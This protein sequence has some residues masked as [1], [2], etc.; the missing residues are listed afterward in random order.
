MRTMKRAI[1]V[2]GSFVHGRRVWPLL[3][4]VSV[5][6]ACAAAVYTQVATPE[7]ETIFGWNQPMKV[8]MYDDTPGAIIF[9]TK[10][11]PS[12]PALP[13]HNGATPT[14]TTKVF[15]FGSPPLVAVN[16]RAYFK[17]I[18]YKANMTDSAAVCVI[19]DNSQ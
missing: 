11:I 17:A 10:S 7:I 9:Y 5:A 18:G 13:T 3:A 2:I 4:I 1:Q 15:N 8:F 12:C 6:L 16:A 19:A 14:G